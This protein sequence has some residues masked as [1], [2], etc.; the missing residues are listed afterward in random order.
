MRAHGFG[1]RLIGVL[2][3]YLV[4]LQA[5]VVPLSIAPTAAFAGSLCLSDH[6]SDPARPPAGHDQNCPCCAGCGLLCHAPALAGDTADLFPALR[7]R[8]AIIVVPAL[9]AAAP[10]P[11]IP[12]AQMARGPP[13]A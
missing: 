5:V 12:F 6:S 1:G 10:R 13:A 3:A 11:A 4:A 7:L 9:V 2:A 8:A